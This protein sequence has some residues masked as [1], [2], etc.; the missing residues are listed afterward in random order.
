MGDSCG[1]NNNEKEDTKKRQNRDRDNN[2][3]RNVSADKSDND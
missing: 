1:M 2:I 3:D